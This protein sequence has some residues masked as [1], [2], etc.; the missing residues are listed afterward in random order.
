[1]REWGAGRRPQRTSIGKDHWYD[2]PQPSFWQ[3][4]LSDSVEN[5][6]HAVKLIERILN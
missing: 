4:S 1:M 2:T 5:V 3:T 6:G